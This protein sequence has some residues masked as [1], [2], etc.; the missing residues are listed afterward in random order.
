MVHRAE[1]AAGM[2]VDEE[3][4]SWARAKCIF[5]GLSP[6]PATQLSLIPPERVVGPSGNGPHSELFLV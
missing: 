5:K 4:G 6:P 3:Q 1:R 2:N